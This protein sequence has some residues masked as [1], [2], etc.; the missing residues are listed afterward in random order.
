MAEAPKDN[1]VFDAKKLHS[2]NKKNSIMS[3]LNDLEDETFIMPSAAFKPKEKKSKKKKEKG[4]FD[5][6]SS[7]NSDEYCDDDWLTTLA[8]FS[9]PKAS[10]KKKK[11]FDAF[12]LDKK[13]KKKDKKKNG[14][15]ISH[16]KDFEPEMALLR[17]LQIDQAKF[18]DSLQKKYN[19]MENIKSTARGTGK[20]TTDLIESINQGRSLSMQLVDKIVSVKKTIADLEFKERK[21]FGSNN[22]EQQNLSNYASTYLKQVIDAGRNNIIGQPSYDG[23]YDDVS[24]DDI[25]DIFDSINDSLGDSERSEEADKYLKYEN[26]GV[27]VEVVY[28]DNAADDEDKYYYI[29]KNKDGDVIDD[30]PLPEKNKLSINRST[31]TATDMYGNK[32]KMTVTH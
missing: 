28:N 23:G 25:G 14:K 18:V 22:T 10:K 13:K 8:T 1:I 6:T 27:E 3:Q 2:N 17:N 20:F 7:S 24:D 26:D 5:N 30:Y 15:P 16:K 32:Y 31:G 21:E 19:Q 9:A 11:A 29:A 4:Y 12:E